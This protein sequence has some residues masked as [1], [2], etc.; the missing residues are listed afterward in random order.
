MSLKALGGTALWG[1][2]PEAFPAEVC[3]PS[4]YGTVEPGKDGPWALGGLSMGAS[5]AFAES[6]GRAPAVPAPAPLLGAA[7]EVAV[8]LL[9]LIPNLLLFWAAQVLLAFP[10]PCETPYLAIF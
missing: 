1:C 4:P 2:L 9:C 7:K 6:R 8:C 5:S 10:G 3:V